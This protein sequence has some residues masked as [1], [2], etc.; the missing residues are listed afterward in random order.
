MTPEEITRALAA[1]QDDDRWQYDS[2]QC[3]FCWASSYVP[4]EGNRLI[5]PDEHEPACPYAAAARFV[6]EHPPS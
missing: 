4:S 3:F 2:I 1:F 6:A 5:T